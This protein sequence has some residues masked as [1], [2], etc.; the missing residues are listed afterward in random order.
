MNATTSAH[1]LPPPVPSLWASPDDILSSSISWST[2]LSSLAMTD[3]GSND[4]SPTDFAF[5]PPTN[6]N[7]SAF[8]STNS[9]TTPFKPQAVKA[10]SFSSTGSGISPSEGVYTPNGGNNNTASGNSYPFPG[11][12]SSFHN[13]STASSF[14]SASGSATGTSFSSV[15]ALPAISRE[16]VRPSVSETRRPATAGGALQSRSPF[17]GFMPGSGSGEEGQRFQRLNQRP[18]SSDGK[19]RVT[20]TIEEGSEGMFTNPFGTPN[21]KEVDSTKQV[22]SQVSAPDNTV[23]P[24][25]VAQNNR[26]A[27]E[28]QFNVPQSS[29]QQSPYS[30]GNSSS[31]TSHPSTTLGLTSAPAH[32]PQTGYLQQQQMQGSH[33]Y[34]RPSAFNSRPQ[35][36]DGLPSYPHLTGSV[37]LP[38][39]QSIARQIPAGPGF[40]HPPTPTS[41]RPYEQD[42]S[43]GFMPFRDDRSASLSSLQTPNSSTFPGDRAYSIDSGLAR[44]GAAPI[45]SSYIGSSMGVKAGQSGEMSQNEFSLLQLGGPAPKKRPR[46]RFDEIER[47]YA[48]GW[49]GCEKSYGTL[50]HLNAHVAMQKHGEKRL[51]SEF[52]EMRK[53][54]RK[55]KR[56]SAAAVANAQYMASA[57]A[58]T[59][60]TSMSSASGESD[61][62]RRDSS[63]SM[64]SASDFGHRSS[65]SYPA[66]YAPWSAGA[67]SRPSTSSSSISSID[68]RSYYPAPPQQ[69]VYG[70]HPHTHPHSYVNPLIPGIGAVGANAANVRRLSAPQHLSMPAP[71]DGFRQPEGDHPTPTAQNPFPQSQGGQSHRAGFPFATLTS[72]MSAQA[73]PMGSSGQSGDNSYGGGPFAFQR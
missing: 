20:E 72:P 17:A 26:R 48:C 12:F 58:W 31:E 23:D 71:L 7:D 27:S 60:R 28:P 47:L 9:A 42:A 34:A 4:S 37:P 51:P 5:E 32:T 57:A 21:N 68:G 56:E 63:A 64:M 53:A 19:L 44:P 24:H 30:A 49:N 73:L 10:D 16:F 43:K 70:V 11:S 66:G 15:D 52:K 25:Y 29:W 1:C 40:Y 55:K 54:W 41:A 45:R 62:D 67:E 39:A 36:S 3:N 50:N 61:W 14:S 33:H 6:A 22:P 69:Q 13:S 18:T 65:Q 2:S 46:R 59:Q 38:S 8:G 35:T